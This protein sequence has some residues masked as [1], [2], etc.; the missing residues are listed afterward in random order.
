M[1]VTEIVVRVSE[2]QY[3]EELILNVTVFVLRVWRK[4][5]IER[6]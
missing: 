2:G 1:N 4:G 3:G 6:N 5:N